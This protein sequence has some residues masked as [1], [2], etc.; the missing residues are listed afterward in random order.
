M[1]SVDS[2]AKSAGSP[3]V[4][5]FPNT[6]SHAKAFQRLSSLSLPPSL[7]HA[8]LSLQIRLRTLRSEARIAESFSSICGSSTAR[9]K[10]KSTVTFSVE[11]FAESFTDLKDIAVPFAP[12]HLSAR[13]SAR[14]NVGG[15]LVCVWSVV[16][17]SS[18]ASPPPSSH[19]LRC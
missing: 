1:D 13:E 12:R 19:R 6:Y 7:P 14:N 10:S 2:S 11:P 17:V 3:P 4:D 5:S 9:P 18:R 15:G 16:G 8:L